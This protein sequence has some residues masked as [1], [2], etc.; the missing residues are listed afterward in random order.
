M[1]TCLPCSCGNAQIASEPNSEGEGQCLRCGRPVP[2]NHVMST[3][4]VSDPAEET[5]L[6]DTGNGFSREAISLRQHDSGAETRFI[7]PSFNDDLSD[8][9]CVAEPAPS[10]AVTKVLDPQTNADKGIT[11]ISPRNPSE[12]KGHSSSSSD[13]RRGSSASRVTDLDL[14]QPVMAAIRRSSVTTSTPQLDNGQYRDHRILRTHRKGGMGH[15]LIAYDQHLK[16]EVAL[17]ELHTDG[18]DDPSVVQRFVGEAEVTAQLEH[19]GIVP[20]HA[21]GKNEKSPYYTMKLIKGQT[22]QDAIKAYHKKPSKNELAGLVRRLASVCKTMSYA[23]SKGFIHRD[24]KPANIMLGEHGETLVMDWGLAKPYLYPEEEAIPLAAATE[25]ANEVRQDARPELTMVGSIVGTLAFMSPE[26]ALSELGTVGPL[27]DVFSL[28]ALLYYLLT[29]QTAFNGRTTQDILNK[30][31][32]STPIKPSLIKSVP[33]DLEAICLKAMRR[34]PDERYQSA[35]EMFDDLCRWLDNEPVLARKENLLQRLCRQIRRNRR[36]SMGV[37][38]ILVLGAVLLAVGAVIDSAGRARAV[39]EMQTAVLHREVDLL[40]Q[41]SVNLEGGGGIELLKENKLS[42]NGL[43]S[44]SVSVPHQGGALLTITA[45]TGLMWDLTERQSLTFSLM[46]RESDG[47][48]P[49]RSF[50]VRLGKGSGYF[51]FRPTDDWKKR[52]RSNWTPISIPLDGSAAW[53]KTAIND[54][55]PDRIR[56]IELHFETEKPTVFWINGLMFLRKN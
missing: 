29:G 4:P 41:P 50:F 5:Q 38:T 11:A 10:N 54:P 51:E 35:D 22:F 19:P 52:Y 33:S 17:K 24:L 3:P 31:R 42:G 53:T 34:A 6:F 36:V 25:L 21:L 37:P 23:H 7:G 27:S 56:W 12:G 14:K 18:I 45:P 46:Q 26:Q 15:I 1:A 48:F 2:G 20:I 30:V 44:L 49:L 13:S 55:A 9:F 39:K 32:N 47:T 8:D 40:N 28:G 43:P 16:R